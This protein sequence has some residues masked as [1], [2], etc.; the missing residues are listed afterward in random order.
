MSPETIPVVYIVKTYFLASI[1]AFFGGVA[2]AIQ[3]VKKA[4]WKGWFSFLGDIV[5]CIFFGN[6]FYQ[7]GLI[8][9]PEYAIVFTSLGSFWGAKSFDYIKDWVLNSLKANIK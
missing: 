6:V 5:V 1:F 8:V 3:N 9:E 7:F 2:H 4:G